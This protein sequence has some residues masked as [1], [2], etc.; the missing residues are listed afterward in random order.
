MADG[1]SART[2]VASRWRIR[3]DTSKAEC[4][5]ERIGR[6]PEQSC[7]SLHALGGFGLPGHDEIAAGP[8]LAQRL[9]SSFSIRYHFYCSGFQK[10][11][12][13]CS[14]ASAVSAGRADLPKQKPNKNKPLLDFFFALGFL[15]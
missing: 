4:G 3:T 6:R 12:Q 9:G 15:F 10:L 1:R 7:Q 13:F 8:E 11:A 14:I 5:A 2:E